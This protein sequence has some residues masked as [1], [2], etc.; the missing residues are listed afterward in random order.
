MNKSE[1]Y[2]KVVEI[3]E[4]QNIN[5]Q[6]YLVDLAMNHTVT[7]KVLSFIYSDK[8]PLDEELKETLKS[9]TLYKTLTRSDDDIELAKAVS[10]FIT[11]VLIEYKNNPEKIKMIQECIEFEDI[12]MDLS[13]YMTES[14]VDSLMCTV[15]YIRSLLE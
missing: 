2:S 13:R 12:M 1:A 9:K 11:H 7:P 4:S 3:G 6:E 15:E 8:T 10:S 14:D 5:V